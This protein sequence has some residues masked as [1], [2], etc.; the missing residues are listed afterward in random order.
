MLDY[1]ARIIEDSLSPEGVRLTTYEVTFPRFILAEFNTHRVLSRNSA[2]SRAIPPEKQIE[3]LLTGPFVP[4]FGTRVKGMGSGEINPRMVECVEIWLEARDNAVWA[5]RKLV[6]LDV[7]KARVNRLLEPFMWHT[8]IASGTKWTNFFGLRTN[9][10]AQ[11]EFKVVA[12]MMYAAY[13]TQEPTPRETGEWHLPMVT[14][15]ERRKVYVDQHGPSY[16]PALL[17]A[18][19]TARVSFDTHDD[20]EP[21]P[22]SLARAHMLT[23]NAHWSPTEHQA[24]VGQ[25]GLSGN[26]HGDWEQFRKMFPNE[27]DWYLLMATKN[28][29]TLA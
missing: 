21:I 15:E 26:F 8:V 9:K 11:P 1:A 6:E 2:S 3:R 17:S 16:L 12:D 18:G 14:E 24:C 13:E 7:D 25:H 22:T 23:S 20:W 4:E 5:A 10:D 29:D 27:Q 19:R 28:A